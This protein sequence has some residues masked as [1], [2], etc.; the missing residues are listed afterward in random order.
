[1]A[2]N[3][4]RRVR[5]MENRAGAAAAHPCGCSRP[6]LATGPGD[7]RRVFTSLRAFYA[8]TVRGEPLAPVPLGPDGAPAP[9][10]ERCGACGRPI[11]YVRVRVG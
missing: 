10:P 7:E 11:D 2:L 6:I 8:G 3:L 5:S 9:I 4:A 1:M